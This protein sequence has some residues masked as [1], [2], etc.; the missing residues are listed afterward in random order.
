MTSSVSAPKRLPVATNG[1]VLIHADFLITGIVMTFIGPMLPIVA[2]RW[3]LTDAQSGSL[4]F[5]QFFSSMFGML[6]SGLSV[7]RQGYRFTLIVGA[8]LMA[9]G[10]ALLAS[11]SWGIGIA[12]VCILG[13]GYGLT[14]PAGNLRTAEINPE[15][16]ASALNVINAVWGIGAMSSPFLVALA[17]R[18]HRPAYFLYGTAIG[19]LVLLLALLITRFVPD[20]HAHVDSPLGDK[21][22][23]SDSA[24]P[25]ICALFFIYVGTETSFG[26]WIATYAR[27]VDSRAHALATVTPS[28]YWGALLLGRALAPII[29]RFRSALAIA[30]GGLIIAILGGFAL[31]SAHEIRL[32]VVGGVMAGLGLA[33]IFPISVSLLPG[34][35]GSSARRASGAVF[36]SGNIG[37]AVVPWVVGEASTHAAGLRA[38][39]LIPLAGASAMLVFY[40]TNKASSGHAKAEAA[41]LLLN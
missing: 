30:R 6:V 25:L 11:G 29:L 34:W 24:L 21:N 38:A 35:F 41:D 31:I 17:Q 27:R 23:W 14:T 28:F 18:E 19:L 4:I 37:G 26:A 22:F 3:S 36:A 13:I 10:M 33:S 9:S 40:L 39:F 20:T 32:V 7:Q 2:A 1:I 15:G 12:A 8:L 5:V 16:S